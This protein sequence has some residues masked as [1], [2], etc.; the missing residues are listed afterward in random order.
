MKIYSDI[1][2]HTI[3]N[4]DQQIKMDLYSNKH[5]HYYQNNNQVLR[6]TVKHIS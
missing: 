3:S 2:Q 5:K 6:D 1:L 4:Q